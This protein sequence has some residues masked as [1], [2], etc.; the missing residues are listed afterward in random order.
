MMPLP[1]M[2]VAG[3]PAITMAT[4][5]NFHDLIYPR[6]SAVKN[7]KLLQTLLLVNSC[8]MLPINKHNASDKRKTKYLFLCE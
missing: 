1:F 8:L 4:V 3:I 2:C 7:H 5:L 6:F